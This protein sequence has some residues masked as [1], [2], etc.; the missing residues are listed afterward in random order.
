MFINESAI[1]KSVCHKVYAESERTGDIRIRNRQKQA[2]AG[3]IAESVI[4]RN[5]RSRVIAV[6]ELLRYNIVYKEHAPS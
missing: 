6:S 3:E 4:D 1:C 2:L 5:K